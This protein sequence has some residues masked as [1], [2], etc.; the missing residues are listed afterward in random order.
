MVLEQGGVVAGATYDAEFHVKHKVIYSFDELKDL[1]GSKY[2]Q[3]D[4]TDIY[5]VIKELLDKGISVLFS[6]MACQVE[7]IKAYLKKDY[8]NLYCIDLICMGNP[9][10]YVWERYLNT[11][12]NK[13]KITNINA[14]DKRRGWH[15]FSVCIQMKDNE[16]CK[17]G[18]DN[19]Y[20]QC[21]FKGYTI[22][23]SCYHCKFKGKQRSSD[24]TISDCWGAEKFARELDDNKGLSSIIIHTDKG[25]KLWDVVR[26]K[27][28]FK[29]I[30]A[31]DVSRENRNYIE[32]KDKNGGTE[33]FYFVLKHINSKLA[34]YL[35]GQNPQKSIVHRIFKHIKMNYVEYKKIYNY[36]LLF[37][38]AF[39]GKAKLSR[40]ELC[41]REIQAIRLYRK[42][43]CSCGTIWYQ[44]FYYRLKKFAVKTG[45]RLDCNLNIGK[46]LIIGHSGT[47]VLNCDAQIGDQFFITHGVTI[48]RDIRGK[49]KGAPKI[50]NRVCIRTNSTVVGNIEI[51]DDVLIAPNTFVNFDVP[52]HSIV[53][54]NP[55][56]IHQ[57]NN[58]TEGHLP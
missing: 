1:Q 39:R 50:G 36:D 7:G 10:P 5:L 23:E 16:Y 18:H 26:E 58:A 44:W 3:S 22:R 38:A 13:T 20:M 56:T 9:S 57:C 6:G 27:M 40:S 24:I 37:N 45:I 4:I 41:S 46:G 8:E 53:I 25:K 52:S 15:D 31:K 47:I 43:Q 19:P 21:M 29:E 2:A 54:G 30:S 55:A 12:F 33:L 42:C 32:C 35:F 49:R 48:G 14:K 11:F 17:R 34:F 51:G 28:I